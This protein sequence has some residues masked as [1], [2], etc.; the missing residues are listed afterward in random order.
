[1]VERLS[2]AAGGCSLPVK[3]V[4]KRLGVFQVRGVE[5]L[6]E[7][8]VDGREH[9]AR[10]IAFA[11]LIEQTGKAHR[12][13]Q[14]GRLRLLPTRDDHGTTQARLGLVLLL[15]GDGEQ[16]LSVL[17][18][19]GQVMYRPCRSLEPEPGAGRRL[20]AHS[21]QS[22]FRSRGGASPIFKSGSAS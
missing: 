2:E 3:I 10:F 19:I 9:C 18:A 14:L 7:P 16:Q 8:A 5:A 12:R 6:G 15:A 1:M 21:L 4:L 22:E 11:L 13:A 17:R 20:K